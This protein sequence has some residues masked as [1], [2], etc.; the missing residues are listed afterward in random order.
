MHSVVT[1]FSVEPKNEN[2]GPKSPNNE[3]DRPIAGLMTTN[4]YVLPN[5]EQ[6]NR[7]SVWFTGGSIEV[8][9]DLERWKMIFEPKALPKRKIKQ[10]ARVLGAK[11]IMGATPSETMEAD[12]KM[13]YELNR[14]IGGHDKAYIDILYLDE[15][16]RI[17]RCKFSMN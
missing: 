10:K 5:P 3:V 14:P 6:S 12:G 9:T 4:G 2:F 17:A 7:L 11:V 13:T 15:T 16:L 8:D 1:A